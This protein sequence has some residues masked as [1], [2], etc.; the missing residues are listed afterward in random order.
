MKFKKGDTVQL[1]SGGPVLT[2]SGFNFENTLVLCQWFNGMDICWEWLDEEV[3]K[4]APLSGV[5]PPAADPATDPEPAPP[6]ITPGKWSIQGDAVFSD[7][8][9]E[10]GESRLVASS[11]TGS[12]HSYWPSTAAWIVQIPRLKPLLEGVSQKVENGHFQELLL[13]Q[14]QIDVFEINEILRSVKYL[15]SRRNP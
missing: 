13:Y 1:M 8:L 12:D 3:L 5:T 6:G 10:N 4:P 15:E 11:P 2:A 7:A 9:D 14:G